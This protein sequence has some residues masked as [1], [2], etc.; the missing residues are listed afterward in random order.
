MKSVPLWSTT[1]L[2]IRLN[3]GKIVSLKEV[4]HNVLGLPRPLKQFL[5]WGSSWLIKTAEGL[6]H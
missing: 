3:D 5:G 2:T 4:W 1:H 6:L